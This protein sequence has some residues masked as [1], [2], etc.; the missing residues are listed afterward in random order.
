[1]AKNGWKLLKIAKMVG[2]AEIG[3]KWLE[4][5]LNGWKLLECFDM[6]GYG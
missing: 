2:V 3:L 6:A 4:M 5:A 1:M